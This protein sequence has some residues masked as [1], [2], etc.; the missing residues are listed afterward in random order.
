MVFWQMGMGTGMGLW[1]ART[2]LDC[3]LGASMTCIIR[4]STSLAAGPQFCTWMDKRANGG[5]SEREARPG[6]Q[7]DTSCGLMY[8]SVN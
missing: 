7:D 2:L 1:D 4:Y 5:G 8:G 3:V 6:M